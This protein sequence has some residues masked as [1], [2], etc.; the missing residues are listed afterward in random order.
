M[1]GNDKHPNGLANGSDNVGRNYMYHNSQ[2]VL[3]ISKSP[4][5][6]STKRLSA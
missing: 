3:A 2:A 6:P 5:R 1:S 4:T